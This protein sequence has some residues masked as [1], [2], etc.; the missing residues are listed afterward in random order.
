MKI[1]K[2]IDFFDNGVHTRKYYFCGLRYLKK[3]WADNFKETY[4]FNFKVSG[5]YFGAANT[6]CGNAETDIVFLSDLL[7]YIHKKGKLISMAEKTATVVIPVYNGVQHLEILIP[8]LIKNT[9]ENVDIIIVDDCSPDKD[10]QEFLAKLKNNKRFVVK[11]NEKNLGFVA[12]INYAMS[13]IKTKYAIWLNTD[14]VVPE[15]W[16]ERLL[17]QFNEYDKIASITPFTNSG[18]CFSFPMFGQDNTLPVSFERIDKVFQQIQSDIS[19]NSI[20][21]GTGFCMA[22]DMDCWR[23]VGELDYN[24]FGKGYG[25]ENDWCFRAGRKGYKHLIA[26]DLFVWHRHGGSFLSEEKQRLCKEHQAVLCERYSEEMKKNVPDFYGKDPWKVYRAAAGLLCC[27]KDTVLVIDLKSN[28]SAK[29]G[30]IDYR[31]YLIKEF[32]ENGQDVVL[33]EYDINRGNR[34]T[35]KPGAFNLDVEINLKSFSDIKYLLNILNVKQIIVNNLAFNNCV[36]SV[37]DVLYEI[38]QQY[39]IKLSYKFHDHLS[40]CPSFFL[41]NKDCVNCE[42]FERNTHC[43][44]CLMNNRYKTIQRTDIDAWR[45]AWK[46]LFSCVEEF[47]FFSEYTY[48][49]IR[50]VYPVVEKK[51]TIKEHVSLFSENYTKYTQ[52]RVK[53][54]INVAFVGSFYKEKGAHYFV[55]LS[56]LCKST[57]VKINF[58]IIGVDNKN[59]KHENVRYICGYSRDELGAILTKNNIHAVVYSSIGNETFSY[60]AQEL[61]ILKVPFVCFDNGAHAERVR[62]YKYDLARIADSVSENSLL[63][64]LK[65]LMQSVYGIKI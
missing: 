24:A 8:S 43:K 50:R 14:T 18:V 48:N 52:P 40:I 62:K 12:T 45:R 7:K 42:C 53:G 47:N 17:A 61:M 16:V 15:A 39:N 11:K 65:D 2:K 4:L 26:P 31:K 63:V 60:L 25:E 6:L 38:K 64:V 27:D 9:P 30:A 20:Y 35:V 56:K 13:L 3:K 41:L 55:E 32:M 46:K 44:D 5:H 51:H 49:K 23:E 36:E 21:S 22:I 19:I 33:V 29:S 54:E 1:L 59:I 10:T 57:N 58:Y 34:W 37:I 28:N